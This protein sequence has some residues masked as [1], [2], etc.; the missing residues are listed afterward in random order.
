MSSPS[1][2]VKLIFGGFVFGNIS[3]KTDQDFLDVLTQYNV[4]DIDT[5]RIYVRIPSSQPKI[6]GAQQII[7]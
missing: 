6:R 2:S 7:C 3:S 1:K 5:A 4:V